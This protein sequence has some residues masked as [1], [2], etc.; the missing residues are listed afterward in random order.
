MVT[1]GKSEKQ[2]SAVMHRGTSLLRALLGSVPLLTLAILVLVDLLLRQ[3]D[4]ADALGYRSV[5]VWNLPPRIELCRRTHPDVVLLGSSMLLVLNQNPNGGRFYS[6]T[7]P[8]LLQ[9]Q[10]EKITR[11][12][13]SCLSLCSGLQVVSE[14][15]FLAESVSQSAHPPK[16][17]IFGLSLR[18][19]IHDQFAAEWTCDSFNS[20][21]PYVPLS[22]EVVSNVASYSALQQLF[23]D[24][25][26]YLY[27]D[28]GDF[29][30]IFMACTKEFLETLG[31]DQPYERMG[32]DYVNRPQREGFLWES[33]VPRKHEDLAESVY[34]THPEYLKRYFGNF[35]R[36]IYKQ[37]SVT[38]M[39]IQTHYLQC[40][41]DLCRRK[42]ITLVLVDMPLSKEMQALAAPGLYRAFLSFLQGVSKESNIPL[43]DFIADSPFTADDFKDGV[44]LNYAGSRKLAAEIVSRLQ[45]QFPGVVKQLS[46][47]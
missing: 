15:Y 7:Y 21:A 26:W 4:P 22:A 2:A 47:R 13:L 28:R 19:F 38:T 27:R 32:L 30:N 18:D 14:A 16:V 9:E 43:I 44:H 37:G 45:E 11:S 42:G 3:G 34:R 6:G 40:L 35:Q 10:L 24:H 23:A 39:Q 5:D 17:I 25:F 46:A 33:W 29:K 36:N 20:I 12:D 8:V 1:T 41:I 31:L